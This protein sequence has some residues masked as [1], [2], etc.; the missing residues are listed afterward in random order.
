[1]ILPR[2]TGHFFRPQC[3]ANFQPYAGKHHFIED[4]PAYALWTD[5][6]PSEA[7]ERDRPDANAAAYAL[8][9]DPGP[10]EVRERGAHSFAW[11]SR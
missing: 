4:T 6:G 1:M 7:W 11:T 2:F 9:T 8:W 10:D 3:N 5:P